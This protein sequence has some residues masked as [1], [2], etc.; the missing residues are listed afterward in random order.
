MKTSVLAKDFEEVELFGGKQKKRLLRVESR[1]EKVQNVQLPTLVSWLDENLQPVRS[2][3]DVRPFGMVTLYRTTK[4]VALNPGAAANLTDIGTS[5]YVRL[6]R[7]IPNP[8]ET[9]AALYRITVRDED[10]PASVFSRDDRQKIKSIKGST[11]DLQVLGNVAATENA[12]EPT[13]EYTQNSY[14]ITCD[15]PQVKLLAQKAI[16]QDSDPWQKAL[17]IEKW[18][19]RNMTVTSDEALAPAD[20]VAKHLRGDCTE[21]AMLTAAMCRAAGVPSR[22]A[23]GLIYADV[24]DGPIFAFHMWTEVWVRSKWLPLD[25]TLGKGRVGATHLKIA[26]QSWHD[27]YD[28]SPLL[29]IRTYLGRL[30]I[31]VVR[32]EGK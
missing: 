4:A 3:A 31:D 19:Q 6:A 17:R 32:V 14:F 30:S 27:V 24:R 10:N 11:I 1:A 21:F 23:V 7:R 25:A 29:P 18:V 26:D 20:H 13:A 15:D 16:G 12:A 2:E 28:Q 22:T 9:T 8:Y 5:Q